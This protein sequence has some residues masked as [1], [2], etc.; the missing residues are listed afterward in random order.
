MSE[1]LCHYGVKGM[2][3]GIRRYQNKDGSL[4]PEGK[5]RYGRIP[6]VSN[7]AEEIYNRAY[8]K[9]PRITHDI[10]WSRQHLYGLEHK[11]KTKESIKRKLEKEISEENK[12]LAEASENLKD[13]LRYTTISDTNSFVKNYNNFKK[14]MEEKNYK[15][16][17][18]K[19][20]FQLFNE[21][22]VKHKSVQCIFEDKDG[23]KFE[24]QF[25]TP[26]SQKAKDLKV[27]LY[28]ERRKVGI[29]AKRATEL[30]RQMESLALAVKDPPGIESIK[31]YDNIKK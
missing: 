13:A 15:E 27:P 12:S 24:I 7:T 19:N 14:Y 9:E 18:C 25:Q 16:V 30:E 21:G 2:K 17:R 31:S 3:W 1:F 28:E 10:K 23:Y 26:E 11:L 22:K 4:T 6:S 20:Y 8:A 29:D 5:I